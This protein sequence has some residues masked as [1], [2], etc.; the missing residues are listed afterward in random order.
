MG[1][2]IA[3]C[4]LQYDCYV[5]CFYYFLFQVPRISGI[6]RLTLTDEKDKTPS[7][8]ARARY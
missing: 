7:A 4:C 8:V 1:L 3:F 5:L 6:G 2:V